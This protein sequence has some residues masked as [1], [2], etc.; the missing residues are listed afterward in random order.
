MHFAK[1][2]KANTIASVNL[3]LNHLVLSDAP[4]VARKPSWLKMKM[5]GGE[6]YA[7]LK[8]LVDGKNL[9]TVCQSA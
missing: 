7:K 9:H 2:W 8:K 5:P 6:G 4:P 3:S 1:P